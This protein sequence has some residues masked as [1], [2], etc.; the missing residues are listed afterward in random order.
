MR[1]ETNIETTYPQVAKYEFTPQ[2]ITLRLKKFL[3]IRENENK[4]D[5]DHN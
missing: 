5:K 1:R 2:N 4:N 3:L